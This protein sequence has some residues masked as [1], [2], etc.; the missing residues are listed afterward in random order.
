ML[1]SRRKNDGGRDRSRPSSRRPP[2][3]WTV[4]GGRAVLP[5]AGGQLQLR[6]RGS[7][8]LL[9]L[10]LDSRQV[11]L[12]GRGPDADPA[13]RGIQRQTGRIGMQHRPFARRQVRSRRTVL[14][15][16]V[17]S[18]CI[19]S[20]LTPCALRRLLTRR[21][22]LCCRSC[23]ARRYYE[24]FY[25]QNGSVLTNATKNMWLTTCGTRPY[26]VQ[27][28]DGFVTPLA[29]DTSGSSGSTPGR[30]SGRRLLSAATRGG[31]QHR[32]QQLDAPCQHAAGT[33]A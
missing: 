7:A 16:C 14:D 19:C 13:G 1:T 28:D 6:V 2:V 12:G 30:H 33:R 24:V 31:E 25:P 5:R 11:G 9:V 18:C 32:A 27:D 29:T 10:G 22:L 3:P 21:W 4:V 8:G 23:S 26:N 20:M 15:D 17:D